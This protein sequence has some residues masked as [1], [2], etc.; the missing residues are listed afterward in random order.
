MSVVQ[1]YEMLDSVERLLNYFTYQHLPLHLQRVSQPV[2]E[3]AW[4][5]AAELPQNDELEAGLR[6]LLEAKDCLVRAS[7][8]DSH[9]AYTCL[10]P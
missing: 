4:K 5:Y 3:M 8:T 6:K 10:E 2:C 1:R 7:L 9:T